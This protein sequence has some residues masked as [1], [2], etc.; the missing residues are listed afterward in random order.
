MFEAALRGGYPVMIGVRRVLANELLVP[1]LELGHPI[2]AVVHVKVN[3]L[4]QDGS[5]GCRYGLGLHI[6]ILRA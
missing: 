2:A 6:P 1:A 4:S 3:D 5:P